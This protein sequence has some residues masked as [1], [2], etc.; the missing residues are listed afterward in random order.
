[1]PVKKKLT[2]R[3]RL[4]LLTYALLSLGICRQHAVAR[5]TSY[6]VEVRAVATRTKRTLGLGGTRVAA[7]EHV[8]RPNAYARPAAV[9]VLYRAV[10]TR[11]AVEAR[12]LV[13]ALGPRSRLARARVAAPRVHV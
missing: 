9:L 13:D 5:G 3:T 12:T 2:I 10:V 7:L 8:I 4:T 11:G 1:M 6:V